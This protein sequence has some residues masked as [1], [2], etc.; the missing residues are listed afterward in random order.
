MRSVEEIPEEC[1]NLYLSRL[2]NGIKTNKKNKK[3]VIRMAQS[4]DGQT[5][6]EW[7]VKQIPKIKKGMKKAGENYVE[8]TDPIFRPIFE[9]LG[10]IDKKKGTP[11]K[12]STSDSKP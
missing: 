4:S 1:T 6:G 5:T 12:D 7:F 8:F 2:L 3:E 11:K 9:S 10:I